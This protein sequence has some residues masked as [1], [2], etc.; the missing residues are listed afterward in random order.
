MWLQSSSKLNLQFEMDIPLPRQVCVVGINCSLRR[1]VHVVMH[2]TQKTEMIQFLLAINSVNLHLAAQTIS[3][4]R[5]C[6]HTAKARKGIP[7]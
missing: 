3:N 4:S 7:G 1:Y 6:F 2:D 5:H